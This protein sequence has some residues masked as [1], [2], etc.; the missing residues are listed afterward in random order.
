MI[1]KRFSKQDFPFSS[2]QYHALQMSV[3]LSEALSCLLEEGDP[4]KDLGLRIQV[5]VVVVV[6][7]VMLLYRGILLKLKLILLL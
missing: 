3:D 1:L 7:R 6:P 4:A 5:M 2:F